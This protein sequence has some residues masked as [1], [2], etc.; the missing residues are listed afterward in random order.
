MLSIRCWLTCVR[1][2]QS[3]LTNSPRDRIEA[4]SFP[5][6]QHVERWCKGA[7]TAPPPTANPE[8]AIRIYRQ[9]DANATSAEIYDL[10]EI[11]TC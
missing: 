10:P 6:W 3:F 8:K 5:H 11:I 9:M 4:R 7:R 2:L 1:E